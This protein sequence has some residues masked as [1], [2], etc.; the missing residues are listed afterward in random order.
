VSQCH[1]IYWWMWGAAPAGDVDSTTEEPTVGTQCHDEY[2]SSAKPDRT[3]A[4][5]HV[6]ASRQRATHASHSHSR[7]EKQ[8]TNR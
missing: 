6:A 5:K 7:T 3:S 8:L 1:D 4:R 2:Q